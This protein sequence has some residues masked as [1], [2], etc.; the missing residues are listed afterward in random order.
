MPGERDREALTSQ[1]TSIEI[2]LNRASLGDAEHVF[3]VIQSVEG[4]PNYAAHVPRRDIRV[5][6]QP[7]TGE[8]LFATLEVDITEDHGSFYLVET[9]REGGTRVRLR[10]NKKQ[11]KIEPMGNQAIFAEDVLIG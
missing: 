2:V 3:A 6:E 11:G 5:K 9:E 7:L 10:V 1:R 4:V 8:T